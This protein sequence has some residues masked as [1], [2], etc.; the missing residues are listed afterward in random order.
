LSTGGNFL[1]TD[2]YLLFF[3]ARFQRKNSVVVGS[4]KTP[5]IDL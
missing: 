5:A 4:D 3:C 2:G 1:S